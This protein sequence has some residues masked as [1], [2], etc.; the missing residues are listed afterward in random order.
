MF[1]L[2]DILSGKRRMPI[3]RDH[4]GYV[5]RDITDD[6]ALFQ[7]SV[8]TILDADEGTEVIREQTAYKLDCG[9]IV[10]MNEEGSSALSAQCTCK[11][12]MCRVCTVRCS[13]CLAIRCPACIKNVEGTG[14]LCKKC[15]YKR[16]LKNTVVALHQRLGQEI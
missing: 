7:Q 3:K 2:D 10:G 16:I 13:S 15:R 6:A 1:D 5:L 12:R 4:Q 14:L 8:T 9:H 11:A